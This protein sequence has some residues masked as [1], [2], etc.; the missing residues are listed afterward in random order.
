MDSQKRLFPSVSPSAVPGGAANSRFG[1][2]VALATALVTVLTFGLALTAL[3]D[4]VPYPFTSEVI[5]D[6]WPGDYYWLF[7]AMILMLLFVALVAAVHEHT[8]PDRK[9]YSLLALAVAVIAAAVL[10]IDYYIQATVMQ[11][12][13]EKGQ[14]DGWAIFSQYNPNGIFIALEELG[15]LLMS[16]VF[17]CLVPALGSGTRLEKS[18]RWLF[19]LSFAAVLLA[20]AVVSAL[21]GIDRGDV[22]EIAVISIVWLTLIAAGL[23]LARLFKRDFSAGE[24]SAES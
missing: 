21:L 11:L 5:S 14:L 16:V 24:A 17:L 12:S 15:Y 18:L 13:L 2:R 23:L 19:L 10:L 3:P 20:L 1:R 9:V 6:Q 22:F 4:K 7:P 8:P